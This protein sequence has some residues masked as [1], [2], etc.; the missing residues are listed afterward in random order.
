MPVAVVVAA[1]G[2]VR[3]SAAVGIRRL[4]LEIQLEMD[5]GNPSLKRTPEQLVKI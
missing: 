2:S 3:A 1:A 4:L 5:E